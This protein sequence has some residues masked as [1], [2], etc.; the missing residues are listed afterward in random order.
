MTDYNNIPEIEA[1]AL[2]KAGDEY[3]LTHIYNKYWQGLYASV[4]NVL[5]DQSAG[6]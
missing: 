4:Y 5:K 2:M 6:E 3:T 1:F